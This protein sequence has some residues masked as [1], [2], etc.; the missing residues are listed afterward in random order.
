MAFLDAVRRAKSAAGATVGRHLSRLRLA[1]HPTTADCLE[2]SSGDAA[3]AARVQE[4][5]IERRS[6]MEV[7]VLEVLECELA[8]MPPE[9]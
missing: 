6:E 3:S 1:A 9:A 8:E 2:R 7:G 5:S 4:L